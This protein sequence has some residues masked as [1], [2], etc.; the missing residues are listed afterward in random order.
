MFKNEAALDAHMKAP[1][2]SVFKEF[3]DS[4]GFQVDPELTKHTGVSSSHD[5]DESNQLSEQPFITAMV[6]DVDK[7]RLADFI[8]TTKQLAREFREQEGCFS[9]DLLRNKENPYQY[10][11]YDV[12]KTCADKD[13]CL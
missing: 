9:F 7:D 8:W 12:Y 11:I 10:K 2:V 1:Y 3:A 6:V 5:M 4:G 13:K